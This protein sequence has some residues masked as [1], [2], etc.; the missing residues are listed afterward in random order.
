MT[1]RLTVLLA[2]VA[3]IIAFGLFRLFMRIKRN[4]AIAVSLPAEWLAIIE[5]N[6]PPYKYLPIELQQELQGYIREFLYDK[7]FEGCGG[8]VLTDEIRITIAAQACLLLLNRNVRCYPRLMSVVVYPSAYFTPDESRE[9]EVRLGESWAHGTIVLAW[10]SVKHGAHNFDDGQNL[11]IHEFAHQLDQED[12]SSDGAPILASRSSYT[13]WARVLS[14]EYGR[15]R[16]RVEKGKKTVLDSYGATNPA[17]F[18]AVASETFFEKPEQLRK[19]HPELFAEL[20]LFYNV[21]PSEWN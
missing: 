18:F 10:D 12:S 15:L 13:A 2:V 16:S 8:L 9:K 4:R 5:E 6:I 17:E 3:G 19:K 21:D 11:V 1:P 20:K 7:Q 14:D